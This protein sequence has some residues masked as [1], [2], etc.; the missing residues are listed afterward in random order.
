LA[1]D[2]L[3]ARAVALA[4]TA[5][6][7]LLGLTGLPGAGKSQLARELSAAVEGSVVVP[8]DGFHRTTAE[9]AAHGWVEERG[10]P[11]TFDA[12]A[13]VAVLR[14]LRAGRAVRAPAFDR[15]REEPV[16]D[17]IDVP[18]GVRLVIT[19][20]NYLLLDEPPWSDIRALLDEVWFVE[21]PEPVRVQ[22]LIAR[23][24]EYGRAPDEARDRVLSGSDAANARLVAATRLRADLVVAEA[25]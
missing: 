18:A 19:E 6:R 1:R 4:G 21:V 12:D 11:R 2:H 15:S 14:E 9:L 13:Y 16:P 23:H 8:M 24:V 3:V 17:A 20:G 10:T 7:A 22:R 25:P 5:R